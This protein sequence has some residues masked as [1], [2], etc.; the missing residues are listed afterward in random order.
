MPLSNELIS[1]FVKSTK[2]DKKVPTETTVYGTTVEY[3]GSIY[4]KLDGS[5]LLT[6]V[7]KTAAV[8]SDERVTVMIKNHTATITGNMTSPAA[9]T[10]DVE[11]VGSKISE[12]EI[13]MAY[14]VT[15]EDLE[16]INA[17][18]E[19]IRSAFV[20]TENLEAINADIDK[21]IAKYAELQYV[22]AE[23][24]ETLYVSL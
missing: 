11:E 5:D 22:D 14:K 4:V 8:K 13:V 15:T 20:S 21:L 7:T 3:N 16:A 23:N 1:L 10:G 24:I 18:I 17:T 6:P 12:F 19:N 2:D 9:R